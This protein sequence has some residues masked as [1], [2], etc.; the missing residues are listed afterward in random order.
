MS[1]GE[2]Y[3]KVS[4]RMWND[5]RFRALSA[6]PPNGQTLFV[7]LLSGPELTNIPGCFQAW[8]AG[9]AQALG[10][11]LKGFQEAFGE[12]IEQGMARVDWSVGF[13][14]V[15]KAIF[16][17]RPESPNVVKSWK[18]TWDELPECELKLVAHQHLKAFL[19]GLG[20]A[21]REAFL[22]VCRKPLGKPCLKA[23]PNQ[24]QEQEQEQET[25]IAPDGGEGG[26]SDE[27]EPDDEQPAGEEPAQEA[28]GAAARKVFDFWCAEHNHPNAKFDRKRRGRIIA[29]FKEG[30]SGR[31]LCFAIRGAKKDPFLMGENDRGRVYDG[32]ETILRDA[33]QVERLIALAGHSRVRNGTGNLFD[34]RERESGT[35][36]VARVWRATPRPAPDPN[37]PPELPPAPPP[38]ARLVRAVNADQTPP[39]ADV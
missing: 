1:K 24:E 5:A 10:W 9:M 34:A 36:P 8:E 14:F 16:H 30:F 28:H 18:A 37:P 17:N 12:V 32:L 15:P 35:R 29:R 6:P 7:R 38:P 33:P 4:R 26:N 3:S 11:P 25:P 22:E 31:D 19:E 39:E 21:Y 20:K 27:D 2:R 23:C 13:I